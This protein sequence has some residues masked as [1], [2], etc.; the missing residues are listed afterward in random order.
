MAEAEVGEP[1]QNGD[2]NEEE[3]KTDTPNEVTVDAT[4]GAMESIE[5]SDVAA[6]V[7]EGTWKIDHFW[8]SSEEHLV[9]L[10]SG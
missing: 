6:E 4:S 9:R 7:S 5:H 3:V 10:H 2:V 1:V 8:N